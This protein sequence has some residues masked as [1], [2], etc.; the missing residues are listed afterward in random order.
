M[1]TSMLQLTIA[2]MILTIS[3]ATPST[4]SMLY[5][6]V[7]RAELDEA[8][9]LLN[10]PDD[11]ETIQAAID[12]AED[13]DMVLVQ[14][15][16][17]HENINFLGKNITVASEFINTGERADMFGTNLFPVE[18]RSV[19]TFAN[20]ETEDAQLIGFRIRNG[21]GTDTGNNQYRGGGLYCVNSGPTISN[22]YFAANFVYGEPELSPGRDDRETWCGAG[23][24]L[25]SSTAS[26]LSC[27]FEKNSAFDFGCGI[28]IAGQS[29]VTIHDCEFDENGAS[30]GGGIAV[31]NDTHVEISD[32]LFF[33]NGAHIVDDHFGYGGALYIGE[34]VEGIVRDCWMYEGFAQGKGAG[35]YAG[36]N[37]SIRLERC[38]I[39]DNGAPVGTAIYNYS[40][41]TEIVNCT[42]HGNTAEEMAGGVY[43]EGNGNDLMLPT[44]VNSI[45][46]NNGD[47]QCTLKP[48][49]TRRVLTSPSPTFSGTS[50]AF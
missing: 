6:G 3:A 9:D 20:G 42:I 23:V 21:H 49:M 27:G 43:M 36:L 28:Y 26:I 47:I 24:A 39:F 46:W 22:C 35:V 38:L 8:N 41:S 17:Y 32:C 14:R 33:G 45:I 11:F 12:A 48:E 30:M 13:G 1:R 7:G 50:A 16:D 25:E 44:I 5:D 2:L 10:V 18:E 37:S 4:A 19:V 34:D 29:D 40:A 15:G 31:L